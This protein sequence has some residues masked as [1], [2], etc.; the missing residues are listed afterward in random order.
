VLLQHSHLRLV[1]VGLA[2]GK[3]MHRAVRLNDFGTR[4]HMRRLGLRRSRDRSTLG[5]WRK[6]VGRRK[7]VRFHALLR[8]ELLQ[9]Q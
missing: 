2:I 6:K 7:R 8:V 9:G 5:A 3:K 1:P 4:F